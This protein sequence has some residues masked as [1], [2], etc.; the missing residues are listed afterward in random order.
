[1]SQKFWL[2]VNGRD[3]FDVDPEMPLLKAAS[4]WGADDD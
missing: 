2:N 3:C 4:V 1:M